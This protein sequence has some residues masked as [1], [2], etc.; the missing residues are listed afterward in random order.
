MK[1]TVLR[2]WPTRRLAGG[3]LRILDALG[4]AAERVEIIRIAEW[5]LG[6]HGAERLVVKPAR[7]LRGEVEKWARPDGGR[8]ATRRAADKPMPDSIRT[9][10]GKRMP[11]A[12]AKRAVKRPGGEFRVKKGKKKK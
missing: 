3:V 6:E 9:T 11:G 8:P 12:V 4:A 2:S 10:G 7:L 1:Q 5:I